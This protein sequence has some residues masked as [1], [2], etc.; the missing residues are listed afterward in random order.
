MAILCWHTPQIVLVL[1]SASLSV[2]ATGAM[3]GAASAW[4]SYALALYSLHQGDAKGLAQHAL[5]KG[6]SASPAPQVIHEKTL[7]IYCGSKRLLT[8]MSVN[9][10]TDVV[11]GA[12]IA[13]ACMTL[14][15]FNKLK[16]VG[17]TWTPVP[18]GF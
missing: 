5:E 3:Q 18:S 8:I 2:C 10:V 4:L 6:M 16:K 9:Q 12:M 7:Q 11:A 17:T 1:V 15:Y 14:L 13:L